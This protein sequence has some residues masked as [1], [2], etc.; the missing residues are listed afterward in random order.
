M[1]LALTEEQELLQNSAQ[2][3]LRDNSPVS[4][5]RELRDSKDSIG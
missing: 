5:L 2:E 4:R 1:A 3:F